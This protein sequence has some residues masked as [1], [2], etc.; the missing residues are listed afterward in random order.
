MI[1]AGEYLQKISKS[2]RLQ[3]MK[4]TMKRNAVLDIITSLLNVVKFSPRCNWF[5]SG[6]EFSMNTQRGKR[7]WQIYKM[8]SFRFVLKNIPR[9]FTFV[10]IF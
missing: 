2:V 6:L 4:P 8:G 3:R 5:S 7:Y 10:K 1:P 9:V